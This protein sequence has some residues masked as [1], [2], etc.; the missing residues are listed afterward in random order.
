MNSKLL[1]ASS[2]TFDPATIFNTKTTIFFL[3][4]YSE[5]PYKLQII[6]NR[7]YI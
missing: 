7:T 5:N 2:L 4:F 1:L 6:Q 3:L